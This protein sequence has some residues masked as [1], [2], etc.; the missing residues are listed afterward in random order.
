MQWLTLHDVGFGECTVIGG[1]HKEILMVDCGS[2]NRRLD[3]DWLFRDYVA[4]IGKQYEEASER[5]FV[6]THFH[7]DHYCGLPLLLQGD[8]H[9][10]DRIYLP[11]CPTNSTGVPL[12]M[13]LT[14][15][16]DAFVSGPGTETVRMN[17]AN[18][19]FFQKICGLVGTEP[20]Y[21]LQAGDVLEFDG[22]DYTVLWPPKQNYPFSKTLETLTMEADLILRQCSDPCAAAFLQLKEELCAAYIR[23]MDGFGHRTNADEEE[24][25][26]CVADLFFLVQEFNALL[27]RLH[28]LSVAPKIQSLF[29]DRSTVMAVGEE[30]N[31]TSLILSSDTVLLTGDATPATMDQIAPYLNEA[32]PVVKA[33]HHGTA[34]CWWYGFDEM[35]ITHLLIS[36]GVANAGGK[37]AAEYG[38]LNALHHCTGAAHCACLEETGMC[39]N[40]SLYCPQAKPEGCAPTE[41]RKNRCNIYLA[42]RNDTHVC[43]CRRL[44]NDYR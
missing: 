36:N 21:A 38:R 44:H 10:F 28:V 29:C 24:R 1:R 12:L 18:L 42:S 17:A 19:K 30:I 8:P 32:Y 23:C 14:V 11:C 20:I 2:L 15:W 34:S 13:E 35:G 39:C 6:L 4:V 9:Y 43:D 5:S 25:R 37:I 40:T 16:I 27:P 26:A 22:E 7:K 33:P 31:G 41:C 3:R